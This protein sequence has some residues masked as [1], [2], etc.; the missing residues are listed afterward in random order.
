MLSKVFADGLIVKKSYEHMSVDR[1][2][3][4][5]HKSKINFKHIHALDA[6]PVMALR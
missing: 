2:N 5:I 4:T 1:R 6:S 3:G